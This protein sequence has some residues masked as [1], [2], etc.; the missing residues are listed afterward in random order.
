MFNVF[1][2]KYLLSALMIVALVL[3]L[4]I[5]GCK[6]D[7]S[8]VG[9]DN[10][11][12]DQRAPG[13]ADF[14]PK[15]NDVSRLTD[16]FVEFNEAIDPAS[17]TTA[18][19]VVS[20]PGVGEIAGTRS[21][22]GERAIFRSAV[23][24]PAGVPV[25]VKVTGRVTDKAGNALESEHEWQFQTASGPTAYAG[26]DVDGTVGS[27]VTLDASGSDD[28]S[29]R[30]MTYEWRQTGGP[31]VGPLSAEAVPT[32][33]APIEVTTLT[34]ELV[35]TAGGEVSA[36]DEVVVSVWEDAAKR[37]YV[38]MDGN[39]ANAGSA[40]A[41]KK[42]VQA[43]ID[44]AIADG[45]DVYV[46]SGNYAE[47]I[48]VRNGVSVY[49]GFLRS[50]ATWLRDVAVYTTIIDSGNHSA[51]TAT[52][53]SNLTIDGLTVIAADALMPGTSSTAILI[54]GGTGL[55]I[56]NNILWAGNGA[57]GAS[58]DRGTRGARG[59]D[60]ST[61]G[62]N[63]QGGGSG[64]AAVG[65]GFAK[66]GAGGKGGDGGGAAGGN[67]GKGSG[68]GS[69]SSGKVAGGGGG[70][71]GSGNQA[72]NGSGGDPGKTGL[73]GGHGAAGKAVGILSPAGYEVSNGGKGGI[74]GGGSGGGGGGGGEGSTFTKG[75]GGGGGSSGGAGGN[76]G[77]GG[78]GGGGSFGIVVTNGAANVTI[79]GNTITT[80]DGGSGGGGAVGGGGGPPG[81]R[82]T[83]SSTDAGG[84][85]GYG[86][87]GGWGGPGGSGAG[88]GGG[89]TIGIL[90][91]SGLSG[92]AQSGNTFTLGQQG[93]GGAG[94]PGA[95][96]GA[97][98]LRTD[99]SSL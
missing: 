33:T 29:G 86:G 34:F 73:A 27:I 15:G 84:R 43:A 71:G 92:I 42:T 51:M 85:G 98:G 97:A 1:R 57:D 90:V 46:E 17:V 38:S 20:S 12:V 65:S 35:V 16:I 44:Q 80:R 87:S 26:A 99:V 88:G 23:I 3:P 37:V 96:G 94:G 72:D 83:S 61:V 75:T 30:P 31:N 40:A 63:T 36:P 76:P 45:S 52:G 54:R 39:D 8:L 82:G 14:G 66:S 79:A 9:V 89:P 41:P 68:G 49:G 64:G 60:G 4:G 95:P 91:Q 55:D 5:T 18:A 24:L 21:V 69:G 78:Q 13:V 25:V 77:G 19:M 11:V 10:E 58:G 59:K 67:G 62:G 22:D 6:E 50:G 93:A 74:G 32:F 53:A 7:E 70:A 2:N 28:P 48:T 56:T 47:T 81:T